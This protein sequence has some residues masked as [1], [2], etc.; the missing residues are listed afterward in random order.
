MVEPG[1]MRASQSLRVRVIGKAE[2]RNFRIAV[3]DVGRVDARDV[4]DH[5]IGA[6]DAVGRL[7][8]VLGQ[9]GLELA[10]DEEVDPTQQDRG[11][12]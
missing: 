7:E 12:G 1:G 4:G 3:G 5:E 8:A 10:A 9:Q 6:V 11:H 2:N